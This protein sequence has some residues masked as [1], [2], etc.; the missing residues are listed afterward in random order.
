M[1][2]V[3]KHNLLPELSGKQYVRLELG[4]GNRKQ[5]QDSI[6]VDALDY[7]CVDLVGD[8]YEVLSA[9][10]EGTVDEVFSSHF[11]EHVSDVPKL[12][13]ELARV[14]KM[15]GK[16]IIVVPHFSNPH[17]YS[18]ITHRQYFGLYTMSYFATGGGLWR[19]VPTY[20]RELKYELQDV[21]LIFKSFP[22]FYLRHG[23]KKAI[24]LIVNVSAYTKELYEESFCYMAPCYEVRYTLSRT[25]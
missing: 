10:P 20:Q 9:F 18:D 1:G 13:A 11:L 6:G 15:D 21:R 4:C 25:G 7:D 14:L 12:L 22:P 5:H 24:E 8:V 17:F 2:F 16:L 23:I 19:K 3:D